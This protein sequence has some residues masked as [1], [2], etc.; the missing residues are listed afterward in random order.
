[1]SLPTH[2][3][4]SV[5]SAFAVP[6]AVSRYASRTAVSSPNSKC[7]PFACLGNP[8]P[9]SYPKGKQK[10][11]HRVFVD[12]PLL[13]GTNHVLSPTELRHLR[14]R[15]ARSGD[16]LILFN[17]HGEAA[18]ARLE[19]DDAA[20]LSTYSEAPAHKISFAIGLPKSPSRADWIVE[21]LTELGI[22]SIAFVITNR[23]IAREPS[24]ARLERWNR[25]AV[26][27][28][29]QCLRTHIPSIE[30]TTIEDLI[31]Q[32]QESETDD[33]NLFLHSGG[34]PLLAMS[35]IAAI[36]DRHGVLVVVGP[37]GGL[38]D[39]EVQ[40]LTDSGFESVGLGNT[41]L[42]V[43][44]AA[45]AAAALVSQLLFTSAYLAVGRENDASRHYPE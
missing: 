3:A 6:L 11:K 2:G 27:A 32:A 28:A 26:G 39:H 22:S 21:K 38:D 45:V 35:S 14:A 37:E 17:S 43:E 9:F 44:T 31:H 34:G 15:R 25:L 8:S 1:M 33:L 16:T 42:R 12:A 30:L 10:S 36:A 5:K 18:T 40:L 19:N 41:R 7:E 23:T 4:F 13:P 24:N 29:K 20:V